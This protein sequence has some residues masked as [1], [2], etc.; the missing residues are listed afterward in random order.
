MTSR[1]KIA[2]VLSAAILTVFMVA[3][4]MS[5]ATAGELFVSAPDYVVSLLPAN[6]RLDMRDY[7][8]FGSPRRSTNVARGEAYIKRLGD[9]VAEIVPDKDVNIQIAVLEGRSDTVVAVVTTLRSPMADSAIDFYTPGWEPAEAPVVMPAYEQWLTP[10]GAAH[11]EEL[12]LVMPFLPVSAAFNDDATVLTL[13]NEAP[14]Y[15]ADED[16][17]RV[18]PWL[19]GSI[20]YDIDATTFK[21]E[22]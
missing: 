22:Q 18:K 16:Y 17:E 20:V 15:L 7:F 21:I 9:K 4:R 19:L 11:V 1:K 10:E 2:A 6:V 8:T 3:Q 12:R 13:T 14:F 5:A